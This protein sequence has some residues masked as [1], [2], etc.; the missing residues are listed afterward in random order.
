MNRSY[1]G[2][3]NR[4]GLEALF[5]ENDHVV[6]FLHRRVYRSRG[7]NA[8]CYWAVMDDPTARVIEFQ[9]SMGES[10]QAWRTLQQYAFDYGVS[11]PFPN[12]RF[13]TT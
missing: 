4:C 12:E 9:I 7:S 10:A 8:A 6:R 2:V 13:A 5:Q 11:L 1:L 3:V